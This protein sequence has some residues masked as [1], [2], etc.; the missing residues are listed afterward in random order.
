MQIAM[1][2][3][4]RTNAL[5]NSGMV[6]I[7]KIAKIKL[8]QQ[9]PKYLEDVS[10][11]FLP[12]FVKKF[13]SRSSISLYHTIFANP[14]DNIDKNMGVNPTVQL[15][16]SSLH[17]IFVSFPIADWMIHLYIPKVN[18]ERKIMPLNSRSALSGLI[19]DFLGGFFSAVVLE[20]STLP[21]IA[22][23]GLPQWVQNDVWISTLQLGH[24][25]RVNAFP[26]LPQKLASSGF[27]VLQWLHFFMIVNDIAKYAF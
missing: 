22:I 21:P 4:K 27:S 8:K 14:N 26:Q 7:N 19:F 3:F 13:D 6:M 17:E 20:F 2:N 5:P 11:G 12:L 1:V 9:I 15:C 25:V 18:T 23:A 16:P 10:T 24:M